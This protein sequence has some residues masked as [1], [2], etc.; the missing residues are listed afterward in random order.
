MNIKRKLDI[1]VISDV[2]LGTKACHAKKLINY[3]NSIEPKHLVLNGNILNTFKS[4]K[5]HFS[6][7][8]FKV[9]KKI[10][11]LS[12]NGTKVTYVKAKGEDAI[13]K[14]QYFKVGNISFVNK[15]LLNVDGKK[16]LIINGDVFDF[17]I[18]KTYT[19]NKFGRIGFESA[20]L[21]NNLF[22]WYKKSINKQK[23]SNFA[24]ENRDIKYVDF[25]ESFISKY[26]NKKRCDYV[27]CGHINA[28][29]IKNRKNGTVKYLNSGNWT[30][31]FTALEYRLKRW[32]LYNYKNDKLIPFVPDDDFDEV[33][34]KE[35]ISAITIVKL[36]NSED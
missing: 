25:F 28:P 11:N 9:L 20:L 18:R 17:A 22:N 5:N 23:E 19:L 12:V 1:V 31:N 2:H 26:A 16:V 10:I 8:H 21:L 29:K 33:K 30:E 13:K 4:D 6:K 32:K 36:P 34:L 35:F 24:I 27:I 15:L 3:L 7:S 14:T